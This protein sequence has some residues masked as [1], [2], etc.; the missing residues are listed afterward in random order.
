MA[1][2]EG[3]TAPKLANTIREMDRVCGDFGGKIEALAEAARAI[4]GKPRDELLPWQR[5]TVRRL[6]EMIVEHAAELSN[7]LNCEAEHVGCNYVEELPTA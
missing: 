1:E 3:S 7:T 6:L 5:D 2:I 4:I